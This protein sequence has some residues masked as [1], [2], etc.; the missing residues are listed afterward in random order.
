MRLLNYQLHCGEIIADILMLKNQFEYI[1]DYT[2]QRLPF[3]W[4]NPF[5]YLIANIIYYIL[6]LYELMIGACVISFGF[7]SYLV[8]I[9][10]SKSIK[11]SLYSIDQSIRVKSE[12]NLLFDQLTEFIQLHSI[13]KQ[14]SLIHFSFLLIILNFNLLIFI[15]SLITDFSD[16]FEGFIAILFVYSLVEICGALLLIQMQ[17]VQCFF[18]IYVKNIFA[19]IHSSKT[20]VSFPF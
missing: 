15:F 3:D 1:F 10:M 18:F 9:A 7:G 16:I 14:L 13:T 11:S 4:Q 8:G 17:L 2:I 20:I 19:E 12:K 5:G 6:I